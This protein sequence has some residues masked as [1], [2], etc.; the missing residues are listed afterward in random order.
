VDGGGGLDS[1]ID[2]PHLEPIPLPDTIAGP[3]TIATWGTRPFLTP[4]SVDEVL[5]T[6]FSLGRELFVADWRVAPD[7]T[8]P[9]IDGL[10]PLAHATSCLACHP[11][12]GRPPSLV[13]GGTVGAGILFRLAHDD[14]GTLRPDPI[15]GAQLQPT[16]IAGVPAEAAITFTTD[17]A[18]R[19]VF[20]FTTHA[21]YGA[22]GATTHASPRLSPHLAGMGLL[23]AVDDATLL[24]LE[25]PDD[26]DL[27]G[28]SGRAAR[29]SDNS[30]G[31][32]GWKAV[33]TG[34]RGQTAAA[35]ANDLGI[36]SPGHADDCTAAQIACTSSPNGGTPEVSS[37]DIE[38][39]DIFTRYL[40]VTA[41]RRDN[42]DPQIVRG[43]AVFTTIGCASC[44]AS[45]LTTSTT[46]TP[47]IL[48]NV[49]FHPYTDLL[50]H[51]LGPDLADQI[52]EGVATASEWR[53]PPL[54]GLGLVALQPEAR[55]LHDGRARTLADAIRWHGGEATNARTAFTALS[56]ED[57]AALLAFL[58]SL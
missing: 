40:G 12:T 47:A 38:A 58:A 4:A 31:R 20:S 34:L 17:G 28:I 46:A 22:L 25:D 30:V 49:T 23:E 48:A 45:T 42:A 33:Q 7:V 11:V 56:A 27:D 10:G 8:R 1:A 36:T 51:D 18:G 3:L 16:S 13:D 32:F 15:F 41:A 5:D 54:W 44:H 52:G 35:F 14:N 29:F 6:S 24:A 21:T 43:H 26:R 19:P 55:F 50:L 2:A 39:V 53:T 57:T 9:T 37:D